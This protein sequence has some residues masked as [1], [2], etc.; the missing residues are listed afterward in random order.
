MSAALVAVAV[1]ALSSGVAADGP[2]VDAAPKPKR[3][4]RTIEIVNGREVTKYSTVE[5]KII[6]VGPEDLTINFRR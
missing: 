2:V 1:V 3:I 5:T 4:Y 6:D